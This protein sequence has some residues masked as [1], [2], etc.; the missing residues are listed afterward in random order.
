MSKVSN[1][2]KSTNAKAYSLRNKPTSDDETCEQFAR[3]EY[4]TEESIAKLRVDFDGSVTKIL[5]KLNVMNDGISHLNAEIGA[6]RKTT[7]DLQKLAE[8]TTARIAHLENDVLPKMDK[9]AHETETKLTD[10]ITSLEIHERKLNL[11]FY[12]IKS[13][14][15]A[16]KTPKIALREVR[17]AI[18]SLGFSSEKV[19][20]M[21]FVN[22]HHLPRRPYP[23]SNQERQTPD[24]IIARFGSMFDRD[25]VLHAFETKIRDKNSPRPAFNIRTDL[26]PH[27]KAKRFH[28]EKIAYTLRKD[29]GKS[30]RVRL[31]G[32]KLQL[33]TRE[34]GKPTAPWDQYTE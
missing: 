14:P 11:L 28:L 19:N 22:A 34:K 32:T 6:V 15:G 10:E 24:P 20:A 12:G 33:E 16:S 4:A 26:P 29:Q 9:H 18:S 27:L 5:E 30:T 8:D 23:G 21:Y 3:Q 7:E 17:D 1:N 13:Q 31:I 2:T 25:E